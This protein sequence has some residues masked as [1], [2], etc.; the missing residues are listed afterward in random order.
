M[1][2][3]IRGLEKSEVEYLKMLF[4]KEGKYKSFNQFL[5]SM[6]REKIELGKLNKAENLYVPYLENINETTNFINEQTEKQ[7]A[8]LEQFGKQMEKYGAHI[9]RWLEYEGEVGKSE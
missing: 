5:L 7:L 4:K 8:Q 2:I 1:E 9:S 3:L 6:C